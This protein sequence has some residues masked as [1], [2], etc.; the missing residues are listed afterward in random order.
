M[1]G[2][3]DADTNNASTMSTCPITDNA[4]SAKCGRRVLKLHF[5]CLQGRRHFLCRHC[6]EFSYTSQFENPRQRALRRANKLWQRLAGA[7]A[8]AE[9][10]SRLLAEALQ[11]ETQAT[12]ARTAQVQRLIAWLDHRPGNRNREPQFTL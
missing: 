3:A 7:N 5:V 9:A 2:S 4:S 11:A 12:E 10:L 8:D 1:N 6:S